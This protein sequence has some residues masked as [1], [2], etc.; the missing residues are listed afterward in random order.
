ML[1]YCHFPDMLLATRSSRL[2]SLYRAPLD[3]F[4]QWTTGLARFPRLSLSGLSPLTPARAGARGA[5]E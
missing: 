3:A 5:G 4:E 2:R 1:F